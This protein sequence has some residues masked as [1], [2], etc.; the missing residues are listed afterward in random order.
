MGQDKLAVIPARLCSPEFVHTL[1]TH[2]AGLLALLSE[3]KTT[4]TPEVVRPNRPL[5]EREIWLLRRAGAEND[6][7]IITALNLF[8][9]K[10]VG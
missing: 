6:P 10:I 2:K 7:I 9:S 4:R 1:R 3:S 8:N 5:T